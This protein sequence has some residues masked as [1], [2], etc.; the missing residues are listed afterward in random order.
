[1]GSADPDERIAM[2]FAIRDLAISAGVLP[3]SKA[4][5]AAN[6]APIAHSGA[7]TITEARSF[8]RRL[9]TPRFAGSRIPRLIHRTWKVSDPLQFPED[10]RSSVASFQARNEAVLQLVWSDQACAEFVDAYY[11]SAAT[12]FRALPHP[13]LRADLFRY[14]VLN[15]F[16]GVYSDIDTTLLRAVDDWVSSDLDPD[17]PVSLIIGIEADADMSD[18][19]RWYARR[20]QWCQWTIAAAAGHPVLRYVIDESLRRIRLAEESSV[21]EL[22]GPGVWTDSVNRWLEQDQGRGWSEFLGLKN[23]VCVGDAAILTITAFSPGVGHMGSEPA[24]SS[25]ALVEHGFMGSW[26]PSCG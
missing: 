4:E 14:M 9:P 19:N 10:V 13:V 1:M 22:T 15:I 16:G 24:S 25:R 3:S 20:L 26:K 18:W 12:E 6:C 17:N 2:V 7:G 5:D 23:A 8:V 21:M 11:P